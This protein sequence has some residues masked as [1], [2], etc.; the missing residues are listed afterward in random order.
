MDSIFFFNHFYSRA[1]RTEI[2]SIMTVATRTAQAQAQAPQTTQTILAAFT[3]MSDTTMEQSYTISIVL[4]TVHVLAI[5]PAS[6]TITIITAENDSQRALF[7]MLWNEIFKYICNIYLFI[8][9]T[10]VRGGLDFL[11]F[12]LSFF[13][14]SAYSAFYII[15]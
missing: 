7:I 9:T 5:T 6:V 11:L 14:G 15:E 13:V 12:L 2:Y 3:I 4:A 10:N 1:G 8:C